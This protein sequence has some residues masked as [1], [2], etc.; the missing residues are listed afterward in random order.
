RLEKASDGYWMPVAATIGA[1]IPTPPTP[2]QIDIKGE[3]SGETSD[4]NG[5]RL[6]NISYGIERFYVPEGEGRA[7]EEGMNAR[8]F[9][10]LAAVDA[11]GAAQIKGLM[12]GDK[13]LYAEPLY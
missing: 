7:I 2:E 6:L 9:G 3:A 5:N 8:A 11:S 10:I 1:A 12:D 4:A 13:M